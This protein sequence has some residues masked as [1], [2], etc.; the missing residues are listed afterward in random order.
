MQDKRKT[1][2]LGRRKYCPHLTIESEKC[3]EGLKKVMNSS[4]KTTEYKKNSYLGNRWIN[5]FT[6]PLRKDL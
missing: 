3:G 1:L 2:K 5:F 4:R 6:A